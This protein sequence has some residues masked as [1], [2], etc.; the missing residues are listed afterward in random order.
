[1]KR[2]RRDLGEPAP[3]PEAGIRRAIEIMRGGRLT[4]YGEFGG[5]G[6]E[7]AALER[8]FARYMGSPHAVAVN[9]CGSALNIALLCAGVKPGD[10]V[11]LNAFTLAP[12]PGAI[13][14]AGAEPLYVECDARYHID[15]E[16]L[17]RK[18]GLGA[19]VLLLSHMR[20]HIADMEAVTA[21][22]RRHGLTLI[23]DCAHTL[24]ARWGGTP[25]GRFGEFGCFSLQAYKHIN[26]GEG[27]LLITGDA[28]AAARA[29][30]Y[31]GSYMLYGQ[32]GAAP[33][34]EVF[35]RHRESIPNLSCRMN[36]VTAALARPQIAL[37]EERGRDWNR[38]YCL[39]A[40]RFSQI[41]AV[42]VPERDPR[43]DYIAS[44]IQFSLT[45]LSPRRITAV[46]D[47]CASR[48]VPIKWFGNERPQGFTATFEH[49]RYV[50]PPGLARTRAV[51]QGLCDLRIPL[52]L[53]EEDCGLIAEILAEAIAKV[54][55]E[56]TAATST[57][58][59]AN[60]GAEDTIKVETE[61]I[62]TASTEGIATANTEGIGNVGA[63]G[64]TSAGADAI[65]AAS[66]ELIANVGPEAIATASTGRSGNR[67]R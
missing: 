41:D 19:T 49:W 26:A 13:V 59:I 4:R 61:G 44:S 45:G 35:L 9:S 37:L 42:L 56:A 46:I 20:G 39:L 5:D 54:S 23:E 28:D 33:D 63:G 31:S 48:G 11:L 14:H 38:S 15:L 22:C 36:E 62:A 6:S 66:T 24:G 60:V 7:V 18:A 29:V 25:S 64:T 40:E 16:D 34:A 30:L 17:E 1:M 52:S 67:R 3:I 51:L 57:E 12:V 8:D 50:D 21:I 2:L 65:A 47:R 55:A 32:N 43:E 27:G 58:A 10:V 53:T